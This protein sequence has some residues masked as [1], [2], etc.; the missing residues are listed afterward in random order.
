MTLKI[1]GKN[2]DIGAA[3]RQRAEERVQ[4]AVTKYFDG[5][6]SG[7]VVIGHDGAGYKA[8][9]TVHL[10]TGTVLKT[11][12]TSHDANSSFESAAERIEKRL[13]R[14]KRRLKSHHTHHQAAEPALE[15]PSYV[16]AQFDDEEEVPEDF[17]PIVVAEAPTRIRTMTVGMAVLEL[18][19]T[20]APVLV[21]RSAANGSVNVV[22][23][24]A[25]GNFGWI[26][27]PGMRQPGDG[28]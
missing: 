17:V 26:D 5:N 20:E 22:Y 21:F 9:C 25:D 14:Y 6:F 2:M 4:A 12:A 1:T 3:L 13:R 7:T 16:L 11:S 18:D 27:P 24:R 8:D 15:A 28:A 10:D 23:R 19:L